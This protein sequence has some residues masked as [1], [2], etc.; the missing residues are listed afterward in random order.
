MLTL[1]TPGGKDCLHWLHQEAK[2]ARQNLDGL[3]NKIRLDAATASPN[4][5]T[6]RD[7]DMRL[8]ITENDK[9][10]MERYPSLVSK[11]LLG[12]TE[13]SCIS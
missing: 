4:V 3:R 12:S 8:T 9:D 2:I 13:E 11:G 1:S 7:G 5:D 10:V 6:E